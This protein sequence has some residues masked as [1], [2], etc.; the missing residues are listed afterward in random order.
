MT[1]TPEPRGDEVFL[2]D[3]AK[4]L[5]LG[6]ML[7]GVLTELRSL[8]PD[9]GFLTELVRLQRLVVAEIETVV[10]GP[11]AMELERLRG[12]LPSD[13]SRDELRVAQAQ[14]VGWLEGLLHGLQVAVS[15]GEPAPTGSPEPAAGGVTPRG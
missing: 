6:Q 1:T 10:P 8:E 9:T 12:D 7:A 4:L 15:S 5:R 11:L 13:A 3:G 14:L 2:V